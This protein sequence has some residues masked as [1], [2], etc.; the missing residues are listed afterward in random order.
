MRIA[1]VIIGALGLFLCVMNYS[2]M[3]VSLRN[4][5]RGI[6]RHISPI[7]FAAEMMMFL[8]AAVLLPRNIWAL[9]FLAFLLDH[10]FPLFIYA[11]VV[12]G[13]FRK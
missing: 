7:P 13:C 4:Q 9:S 11:V 2:A 10:T 6:D 1:A 5:K 12:K 8:P 3:F